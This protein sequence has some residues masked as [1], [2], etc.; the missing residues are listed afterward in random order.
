[1]RLCLVALPLLLGCPPSPDKDDTGLVALVDADGDG[2]AEGVDCDD[3][4]AGI[5]PGADEVCN[6]RD[7]DCDGFVDLEDPGLIGAH[8][9]YVDADGD[10]H[11]DPAGLVVVCTPEETLVSAGD[12]C[13][14]L[15][16]E[17]HPGAEERCNGLD[18]DCDE[19]I[20]EGLA[21]TTW[22]EDEDGDGYGDP[23]GA[24]EACDAPEGTVP[25][26]GDCDD[27]DAAIHPD[28]T[29]VC[30]G[31]D[32]DC[33]GLTDDEDEV[34]D[35][36]LWY[37]DADGDGFGDDAR[38]QRSC[39]QPSGAVDLPGD[40]DDT[41]ASVHPD[42]RERCD[43]IDNDCDGLTD[44]EDDSLSGAET[45]YDDLDG[46][47]FGDSSTGRSACSPPAGAVLD[48]GDCDDGHAWAHPG[49]DEYCNG[50]DDDCD[51]VVDNAAVDEL[52]WY[53]DADGD[54]YGD[55]SSVVATACSQPAGTVADQT[56]CDDSDPSI[57]PG[58]TEL[59]NGVDDDC[60][61]AV[62][63][64]APGSSIWYADGDGDGYGD[65][66]S[67]VS[68]CTTPSGHVSVDGDCDDGDATIHPGATEW[69][70]GV[71]TDCDGTLDPTGMVS[72]EDSGGAWSD[73]SSSFLAVSSGSPGSYAFSSDGA[74]WFCPGSFHGSIEVSAASAAIIGV[75][76][77]ASTSLSAGGL[78]AVI[79]TVSGASQL[80]LRGMSL[81]EGLA[82]N[83]GALN[84]DTAGLDVEAS[85]L[86]LAFNAAT[87]GGAVYL[88]DVGTVLFDEVEIVDC[89]A[90]KGGAIYIDGGTLEIS[91]LLLED[92]VASD[93]GGGIWAKDATVTLEDSHLSAQVASSKGGGLYAD[94]VA[95]TLIDDEFSD[96]V[97]ASKGGGLYVKGSSVMSMEGTLVQDNLASAG[98]GGLYLESSVGSCLGSATTLAPE[99][100]HSNL[101]AQG[102]AIYVKGG[103]ASWSADTCDFGTGGNDN[104]ADDIF[105]EHSGVSSSYGDDASFSCD[106]DSCW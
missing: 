98:G 94:G 19:E 23:S 102:G 58:S 87:N 92:N 11:G 70:D 49:A 65:T 99:G 80:E 75:D 79:T 33:D 18:D 46:D 91:W 77:A 51:G 3:A 52:D 30:D 50:Y 45:W 6:E 43:G 82:S 69:C 104:M 26:S 38:S 35:P 39:L 12:D 89:A 2:Y 84:L 44:D 67:A 7:D 53:A 54:G 41:D 61:G 27:T 63:E 105:G 4:D 1:M 56:D 60:D 31:V 57:H 16:A 14:D 73:V 40:C 29:E 55:P 85:D 97:C 106:E 101:A 8:E 74:L 37:A 103:S 24:R 83:G 17:I 76:G 36:E 48:D 90:T 93:Q 5:H 20:D 66:S 47:G 62:D 10:G 25:D 15:D 72:F 68:S 9:Y 59:C 86:W 22:Y 81:I 42:A 34:E 64:G 28:A 88:K 96:C 78:G 21:W 71:D 100:F 32:N 95:L 13:D